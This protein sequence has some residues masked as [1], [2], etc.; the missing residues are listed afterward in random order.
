MKRISIILFINH[1][2]WSLGFGAGVKAFF[3][4]MDDALV[5]LWGK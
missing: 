5:Y 2:T 3:G 1:G 4:A